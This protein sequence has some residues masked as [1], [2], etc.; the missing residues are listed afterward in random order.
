[1]SSYGLI[2]APHALAALSLLAPLTAPCADGEADSLAPITVIAQRLN[3]AR[4]PMNLDLVGLTTLSEA[5][6]CSRVVAREKAAALMD[7]LKLLN[8]TRAHTDFC[9]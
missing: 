6:T 8:S 5:E 9:A 2:R 7:F 1:M 3:D 4:W